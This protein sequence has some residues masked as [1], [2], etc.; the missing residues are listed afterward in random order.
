[1]AKTI[2][3]KSGTNTG[4]VRVVIVVEVRMKVIIQLTKREEAKALPI[5]WRHSPGVALP[6]RTYVIA[7]DVARALT[8]SGVQ[9]TELSRETDAPLADGAGISERV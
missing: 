2:K 4:S 9:F 1:M 7:E 5:M 6:D 3:M 8:D